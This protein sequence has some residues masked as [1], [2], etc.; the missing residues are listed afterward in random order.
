MTNWNPENSKCLKDCKKISNISN[1]DKNLFA[2]VVAPLVKED[3]DDKDLDEE[4]LDE[5]DLDEEEDS[6]K[7]LLDQVVLDEKEFSEDF[8]ENR[9]IGDMQYIGYGRPRYRR[10]RHR[11]RRRFFPSFYRQPIIVN[12]NPIIVEK[13]V[14]QRDP[15]M[16]FG[17]EKLVMLLIVLIMFIVGGFFLLRK[18]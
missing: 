10:H 2:D 17:V 4:H 15:E 6:E 9:R 13:P 14:I 3:L 16:H 5:E 11:H 7:K 1:F 12:R 18:N 8:G